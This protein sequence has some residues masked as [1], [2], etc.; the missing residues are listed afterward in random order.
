MKVQVINSGS[1]GNC[2]LL[3]DRENNSL[4]IEAGK[5]TF[6]KCLPLIPDVAKIV[7]CIYSHVHNDHAGDI[8][9]VSEYMPVYGPEQFKHGEQI[10]MQL[11][12]SY[13]FSVIPLAVEHDP[14]ID[15]FAFFIRS[16]VEEKYIF[17]ATDCYNYS[18]IIDIL[19]EPLSLAMVEVNNDAHKLDTSRYPADLKE[20][21]RKTHC[22]VQRAS[23]AIGRAKCTRFLLV[24]PS[25]H[26]INQADAL[27][28]FQKEFPN[29]EFTFATPGVVLNF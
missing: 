13:P 23:L 28:Y 8:K 7:A 29:R 22:S 6:Q 2:Y 12:G 27:A 1:S 9:T 24:H 17:F 11:S 5:G 19:P 20:R 14:G 4:I 16:N 15:C 3:T 25:D 18:R 10:N 26:N 21:I